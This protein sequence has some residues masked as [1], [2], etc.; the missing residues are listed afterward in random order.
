MTLYG[1]CVMVRP[2]GWKP[3]YRFYTIERVVPKCNSYFLL[4]SFKFAPIPKC[5]C[6]FMDV[7]NDFFFL[8]Q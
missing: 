1:I 7:N 6:L 5:D 8:E 2:I 4:L 3:S